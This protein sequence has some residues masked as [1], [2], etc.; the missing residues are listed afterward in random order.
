MDLVEF[1]T[2]VSN[3][4]VTEIF[5][6]FMKTMYTFKA[7]MFLYGREAAVN[8]HFVA[9]QFIS[10]HC[11]NDYG[12]AVVDAIGYLNTSIPETN[13]N[14]DECGEVG[15]RTIS[16]DNKVSDFRLYPNPASS[17]IS[18][19]WHNSEIKN[20]KIL[21]MDG[22]LIFEIMQNFEVIDL[23]HLNEGVFLLKAESIAGE[24]AVSRFIK[25]K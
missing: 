10:T 16:K 7:D 11:Y 25:I 22:N 21:G 15:F 3:L 4:P 6:E 8:T 23:S 1:K 19:Y 2:V 5:H 17:S 12:N 24:S 9:L 20:I 13:I 18:V 14:Y